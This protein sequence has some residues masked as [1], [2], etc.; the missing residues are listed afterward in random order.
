MKTVAGKTILIT[1]GAMGVG[2]RLAE[3]GVQEGA[4]V[5]LWDIND[6]A[7]QTTAAELTAQGG[8]VYTYLVDVS[9]VASIEVNAKRVLS[10]VGPVDILFNNAGIVVGTEFINHTVE[11][12]EKIIRINTL[13]VMHVA[14]VFLPAML[15]KGEGSIVNMAS[16][17]GYIGNPN[18]SVYAASKWAVIGW[19]ESL[20]LEMKK[21]GLKG[22]QVTTV[23]PSYIDTG[24]FEGVKAPLLTPI[25]KPEAITKAIWRGLLK[26]KAFVREPI[27]VN[28]LVFLKRILPVS[29]FDFVVGEVFRVYTSMDTFRGRH[30]GSH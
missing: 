29:V 3:K 27:I 4:R 20:R 17:A 25:L 23:T 24:M 21:T 5:V 13:G 14:R 8:N 19:S 1:G 15:K 18:M 11:Q 10:E 6:K 26:G 9:S 2:R 7:L 30:A 16:A 12:I 22:I 28:L